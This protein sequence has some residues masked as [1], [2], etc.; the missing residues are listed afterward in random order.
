MQPWEPDRT[1]RAAGWDSLG[2]EAR[3]LERAPRLAHLSLPQSA[4][5]LWRSDAADARGQDKGT[6]DKRVGYAVV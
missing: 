3:L 6:P 2:R 1:A 5:L 4:Q